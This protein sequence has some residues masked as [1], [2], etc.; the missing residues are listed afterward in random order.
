M[1]GGFELRATRK[2]EHYDATRFDSV[3]LGATELSSPSAVLV[4]KLHDG[5]IALLEAYLRPGMRVFEPDE[6]DAN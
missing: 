4:D 3:S 1:L 2:V 5:A 6:C